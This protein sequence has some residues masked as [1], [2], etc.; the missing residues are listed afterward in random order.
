MSH[1]H[2]QLLRLATAVRVSRRYPLR[3]RKTL[4]VLVLFYKQVKRYR[5]QAERRSAGARGTILTPH[6]ES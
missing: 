1:R 5:R 4:A 6:A 2:R 3:I